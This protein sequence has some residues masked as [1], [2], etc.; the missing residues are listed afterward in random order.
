[1]GMNHHIFGHFSPAGGLHPGP[2]LHLNQTD[3]AAAGNTQ[4]GV[5]AITRQTGAEII[6]HLHNSG[7]IPRL[8]LNAI[9]G[10]FWHSP[11]SVNGYQ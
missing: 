8:Y 1:M 11:W 3:A 5:I 7:S 6:S 10:D 9:E 4:A 2:P